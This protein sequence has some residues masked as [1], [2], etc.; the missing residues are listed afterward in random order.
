MI[1]QHSQRIRPPAK[2]ET[3]LSLA[4]KQALERASCTCT[5]A[6]EFNRG[7]QRG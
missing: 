1:V 3:A 6:R 5:H 7:G 2:P 4:L